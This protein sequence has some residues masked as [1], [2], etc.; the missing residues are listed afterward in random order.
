MIANIV[1]WIS[2]DHYTFTGIISAE[3]WIPCSM[4][5]HIA[6]MHRCPVWKAD[7][8]FTSMRFQQNKPDIHIGTVGKTVSGCCGASQNKYLGTKVS[9]KDKRQWE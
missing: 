9:K 5:P 2:S 4:F 3:G 7:Q 8:R 1:I 6:G